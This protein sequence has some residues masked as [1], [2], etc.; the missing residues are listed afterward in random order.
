MLG[1]VLPHS[2][3]WSSLKKLMY[4]QGMGAVNGMQKINIDL[5]AF[6][7]PINVK[8]RAEHEVESCVVRF[9]PGQDLRG[10]D[11]AY[12][13][14]NG[15][16]KF[17]PN[18]NLPLTMN[19]I[20]CD[21]VDGAFVF[22]G[23]ATSTFDFPLDNWQSDYVLIPH[24]GKTQLSYAYR[25]WTEHE[26][27]S[28][29]LYVHITRNGQDGTKQRLPFGSGV[30][31]TI[32]IY[33]ESEQFHTKAYLSIP[34]STTLTN[35]VLR[36]SVM[37][38]GADSR[39]WVPYENICP[40]YGWKCG[41]LMHENKNL[42]N[43][44]ASNEVIVN[45]SPTY[46]TYEYDGQDVIVTP[47][48]QIAMSDSMVVWDAF[49]VTEDMIGQTFILSASDPSISV[50]ETESGDTWN[51]N[52]QIKKASRNTA[53]TISAGDVGHRI[54]VKLESMFW[55][56]TTISGIQLERGSKVTA[57]EPYATP[58]PIET[59][60]EGTGKNKLDMNAENIEIGKY[61]N[62]SG[63]I[64]SSPNNF[65][66]TKYI[67]VEP[68][69]A[70]TVSTSTA[71]SYVSVMEYR[72][73]KSF[74][75][76]TL[77]GAASPALTTATITTNEETAYVLIGSNP[78]GGTVT[79]DDVNAINWQF[80]KG[81]SSTAYEPYIYEIFGG[82]Y[83]E[84][85]GN[86]ELT[87]TMLD[88]GT[89]NWYKAD[90]RFNTTSPVQDAKL[91]NHA[92]CACECYAPDVGSASRTRDAA[93]SFANGGYIYIYDTSFDGDATAFKTAMD[94]MDLCYALENPIP[95]HVNTADVIL[96]RGNNWMKATVATEASS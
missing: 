21:L 77:F 72:A 12:T 2:G 62:N 54:G 58:V 34:R 11:Y 20:T 28:T 9:A 38:D 52:W 49:K 70:Y 14:G 40:I 18:V 47:V 29:T 46:F 27:W 3:D 35:F 7:Q 30:A 36:M 48:G 87:M 75:K 4:L 61:I 22:N 91:G 64:N 59:L 78:I 86:G 79:I 1:A 6:A 89:L 88:M 85:T 5:T 65:Y 73:D 92:E 33:Q 63:A 68:S 10:A 57:Y 15:P 26:N 42:I 53:F 51:K 45:G 80:E 24:E 90:G 16:N 25:N 84:I 71:I 81:S 76:R 19:G 95:I 56:V 93:V 8:A 94:G 74:I 82:W 66:N 43:I 39:T 44:A 32:P 50:V 83:D 41:N 37:Y 55:Q 31:S 23:K 69:T 96:Q 67:A 17:K 13:A 60:F